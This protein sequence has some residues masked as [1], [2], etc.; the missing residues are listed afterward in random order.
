MHLA[1][2]AT[3]E[4]KQAKVVFWQGSEGLEYGYK[5][6]EDR[7]DEDKLPCDPLNR[8]GCLARRRNRTL[9]LIA[10]HIQVS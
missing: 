6:T 5:G 4:G 10:N 1:L 9:R 2:R 3:R 8:C 7:L